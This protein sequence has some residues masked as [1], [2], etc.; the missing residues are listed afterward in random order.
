[1][2]REQSSVT[3]LPNE[4]GYLLKRAC[5]SIRLIFMFFGLIL[6]SWGTMIPFCKTRL[7]LNDADLGIILFIFGIGALGTMPL[8]G[9]LV[10]AF[11][12]RRII[13]ISSSLLVGILPLLA[14]APTSAH[15]SFALLIFGAIACCLNV[16]MN[17]HAVA[18]AAKYSHPI[19][20]GI[21]AYFSLGGLLG[22]AIMSILLESGWQILSS[23]CFISALLALIIST[24]RRYLLPRSDDVKSIKNR[25]PFT[26]PRGNVWLLASICF[27]VFLAE[28]AMLDWSAVFLQS[29]LNYDAAL[30]GIGYAIF[31][32]SMA[33]GRFTGDKLIK[34]FGAV[35]IVQI[36]SFLTAAGFLV[37]I[38]GFWGHIE[39][40]GFALIGLGTSNTVPV[41]FSAAGRFPNISAST[42]LTIV[43]TFGYTGILHGPALIG[44]AAEATTL[45]FA[46]TGIALLLIIVG[47]NGRIVQP[48][49]ELTGSEVFHKQH[50]G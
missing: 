16:S 35:K 14:L 10:N 11:G 40:V 29:I 34:H 45:S 22:S 4:T 39:L 25:G 8:T 5:W 21:H 9:W 24:Q 31:S 50:S 23:T 38:S 26:L 27:I 15:L 18:V 37:A 43:T 12:S 20:S 47:L 41:L 48:E 30:V 44:F 6:S 46:L 42:A 32:V 36:G 49:T 28:G 7:E 19:M 13:I 17:S 3:S 33:V 1:M 2:V